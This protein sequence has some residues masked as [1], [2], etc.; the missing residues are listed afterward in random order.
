MW[1]QSGGGGAGYGGPAVSS[2][3][4][5]GAGSRAGEAVSIRPYVAATGVYDSGLIVAGVTPDGG[6]TN[7]GGLFGVEV[8]VGVYGAKDW[9]KTRIGMDYA[10]LYRHYSAASFYNG[11]DHLIE[12]DITHQVA[13][14]ISFL[15]RGTA[16]TSSRPVGGLFSLA[17]L[18]PTRFGIPSGDIFDNRSYFVDASGQLV[19]EIG[20]KSSASISG[21]GFAVRR[22]SSALIGM[23][24]HRAAADFTRRVTRRTTIGAGYQYIHFDFPRFFGESDIHL[25]LGEVAREITRSLRVSAAVGGYRSDLAGVRDVQLD[26]VLVAL[27]GVTTGRQAFNAINYLP[28]GQ[29]AVQHDQ[30]RSSLMVSFSTGPTGGGGVLLTSKQQTAQVNWS[31][32]GTEK[33]SWGFTGFY[34]DFG[35]LGS[36]QGQTQTYGLGANFSRRIRGDLFLSGGATTRRFVASLTNDFQRTGNRITLGLTYSP[37]AVPVSLR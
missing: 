17:Y 11:S 23:N 5:R 32:R 29:F 34:Q 7:P 25:V 35:G 28:F 1:A 2:R 27:F 4:L 6:I 22:Q 16:G 10:G 33:W 14:R 31:F 37:G 30:R 15:V 19:F 9:R 24:G 3:G 8:Q 20:A 26:P 21:N 36:F 13:R 12:M 18:D